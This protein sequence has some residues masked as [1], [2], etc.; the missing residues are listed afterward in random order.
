LTPLL[1][2]S[3]LFVKVRKTHTN[4]SR[5]MMI[6]FGKHVGHTVAEVAVSDAGYL[7]WLLTTDIDAGMRAEIQ[8]SVAPVSSSEVEL[9]SGT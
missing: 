7:D 5:A 3:T 9:E 1:L 6:K 4:R 2:S 8:A